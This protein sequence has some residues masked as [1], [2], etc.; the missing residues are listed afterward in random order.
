MSG[1]QDAE[2]HWLPAN[3]AALARVRRHRARTRRLVAA[4]WLAAL[5]GGCTCLSPFASLLLLAPE[6]S[7]DLFPKDSPAVLGL[8]LVGLI[9]SLGGS[10]VGTVLPLF[11]LPGYRRTQRLIGTAQRLGLR[12]AL[13][14]GEP[15]LEAAAR[16]LRGWPKGGRHIARVAG[17]FVGE[18][19]GAR[20]ALLEPGPAEPFLPA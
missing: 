20:L 19:E 13:P 12:F 7:G 6:T 16:P 4:C 1:P 2:S 5:L 8:I 3:R 14:K 17:L 9:L 10:A 11:R 18:R 15:G